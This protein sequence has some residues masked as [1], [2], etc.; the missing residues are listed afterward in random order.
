MHGRDT[1]LAHAWPTFGGLAPARRHPGWKA[2]GQEQ[3]NRLH[4]HQVAVLRE[5]KKARAAFHALFFF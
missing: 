5:N 2:G 3:P 1:G 4:F